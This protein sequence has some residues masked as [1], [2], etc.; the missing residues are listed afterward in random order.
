MLYSSI[1]SLI[2]PCRKYGVNY[3]RFSELSFELKAGLR[4]NQDSGN[5][6]KASLKRRFVTD[7]PFRSIEGFGSISFVALICFRVQAT[8][9][10]SIHR[11]KE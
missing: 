1:A 10:K 6:W 3:G 5:A 9:G 8:Y 11:K 4:N 2:L 7:F